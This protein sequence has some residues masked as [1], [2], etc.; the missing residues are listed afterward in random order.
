MAPTLPNH[1][2]LPGFLYALTAYLMWGFLPFYMKAVADIPAPEVVAHRILWSLP[3]ALAVLAASRR[4]GRL[5][6]AIRSPRKFAMAAI[7][8]ALISVNWG[9]YVWSVGGG[10]AVDAAL[11]YYINPLF[12]IFLGAMLLGER[13]NRTQNLAIG[14][15]AAAVVILTVEAGRVPLVALGLT[16]TWGL[17]AYFKRR[18]PIGANEG[19]ALEVLI[20]SPFALGYVLWRGAT[21]VGHFGASAHDTLLLLAAGLI[22]AV[23]LMIYANGAKGLRLSTIG[24]MQYIAPSMILAIALIFFH[25]HFGLAQEIAFPLIW[26]ALAIYTLPMLRARVPGRAI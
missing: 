13:L 10:H 6:E 11:G 21:G 26:A 12:S 15:A 18:L 20:L 22:T 14:L 2:T 5:V 3:I 25:E 16:V 8:A 4:L 19:F 24:I 1:D 23:P 17:Y 7:S 9:I